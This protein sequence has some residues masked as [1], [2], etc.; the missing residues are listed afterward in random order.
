MLNKMN[1]LNEIDQT[2]MHEEYISLLVDAFNIHSSNKLLGQMTLLLI[3]RYY[4]ET[5]EF[6]RNLD[7][8]ILLFDDDDYRLNQWIVKGIDQFVHYSEKSNIWFMNVNDLLDEE[9]PLDK[10]PIP[11]EVYELESI[12]TKLK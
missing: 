8:M 12:L 9:K 7:K 3:C 1:G 6:I 10:V 11:E 2:E 5:A 4:S